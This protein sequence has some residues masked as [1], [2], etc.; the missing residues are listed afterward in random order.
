[1]PATMNGGSTP[2]ATHSKAKS[3]ASASHFDTLAPKTMAFT[4]YGQVALWSLA[5]PPRAARAFDRV[6]I[7]QTRGRRVAI[8]PEPPAADRIRPRAAPGRA[9]AE[10]AVAGA[11][12]L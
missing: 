7:R 3:A 9:P 8:G 5:R 12:S 1:M 2:R 4:V 6:E 10:C 11:A